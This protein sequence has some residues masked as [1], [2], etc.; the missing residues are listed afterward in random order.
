MR[1]TFGYEA[2]QNKLKINKSRKVFIFEMF[3][4]LMHL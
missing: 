1:V 3:L 2:G 4:L